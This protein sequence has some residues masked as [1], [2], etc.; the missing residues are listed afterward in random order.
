LLLTTVTFSADKKPKEMTTKLA[1]TGRVLVDN[2]IE[3]TKL[4]ERWLAED[5]QAEEMMVLEK[6]DLKV[7]G[8]GRSMITTRFD[9]PHTD[10]VAQFHFK[11]HTYRDLGSSMKALITSLLTPDAFL[12]RKVEASMKK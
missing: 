4:H 9:A 8:S 5:G 7:F 6:G 1:E 12:Y 2:D 10:V 11:P 3:N